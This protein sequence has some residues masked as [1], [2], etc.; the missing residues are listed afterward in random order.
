M[1]DFLRIFSD[2]L[3]IYFKDE[4][5][6]KILILFNYSLDFYEYLMDGKAEF[7]KEEYL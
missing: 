2:A 1:D 3:N 6:S 4:D 5:K 7:I